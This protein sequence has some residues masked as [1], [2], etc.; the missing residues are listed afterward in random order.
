MLPAWV[1]ERPLAKALS[2]TGPIKLFTNPILAG[3]SSI[4]FCAFAGLIL[5]IVWAS[6]TGWAPVEQVYVFIMM[7]VTLCVVVAAAIVSFIAVQTLLDR[8]SYDRADRTYRFQ[9][10]FGAALG[11]TVFF[12]IR[13]L[14]IR[15]A[16]PILIAKF[17][18]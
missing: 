1:R 12:I 4:Y 7:G 10:V 6:V 15:Y 3:F 5:M 17:G 8:D 16:F 13:Y 2:G 11:I 14:S 18:I 9:F